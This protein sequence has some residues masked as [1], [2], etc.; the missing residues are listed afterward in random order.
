MEK[1]KNT[2]KEVFEKSSKLLEGLLALSEINSKKIIFT[3][4]ILNL[5]QFLQTF[6]LTS[7]N[8]MLA[9]ITL[10]RHRAITKPLAVPWSPGHL[11]SAAWFISLVPSLPCIHT[12]TIQLR[13]SQLD[14][15]FQPEC[16]SDFT[17]W[18]SVWRKIYFSGVAVII[19]IIPLVLFIALYSHIVFQI[20]SAVA[21]FTG[22]VRFDEFL[23]LLL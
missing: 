4:L 2:R 18:P 15:S 11:V 20:W 19:F 12:F 14:S 10:D 9:A 1:G 17:G 7:S 22:R 16:V 23:L 5:F 6:S 8:Y 21:S 13:Q 3:C